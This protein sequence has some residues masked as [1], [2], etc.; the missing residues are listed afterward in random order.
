MDHDDLA[1]I[2]YAVVAFPDGV[3]GGEGFDRLLALCDNGTIRLLDL[4]FIEKRADGAV[5]VVAP[6]EL[7]ARQ[8]ID[9]SIWDG[10]SSG[11]LDADDI[12]A[13]GDS[14]S[15]GEIAV[16][17]VYEN[18]WLFSVLDPW[19]ERGARL[20]ADGGLSAADVDAALDLTEPARTEPEEA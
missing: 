3:L 20:V 9:V 18:T 5:A 17:F 14:L 8:G 2:D 19:R 10:A 1:P 15:P 16:G 12:A 6:Q 13:I 4:E 7:A 11:L